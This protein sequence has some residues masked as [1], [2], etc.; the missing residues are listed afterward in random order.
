MATKKEIAALYDASMRDLTRDQYD[1]LILS[2]SAEELEHAEAWLAKNG[3]ES[4]RVEEPDE[5]QVEVLGT[6]DEEYARHIADAQAKVKGFTLSP[7]A[8]KLLVRACENIASNSGRGIEDRDQ[9]LVVQERA[10][11]FTAVG[12]DLSKVVTCLAAGAP[13]DVPGAVYSTC[14]AV[15]KAATFAANLMYRSALRTDED[16]RAERVMNGE[17]EGQS[18]D[19]AHEGSP[20]GLE[21]D[22]GDEV[23]FDANGDR[24]TALHLGTEQQMLHEEVLDGFEEL[25]VYLSVLPD[26]FGWRDVEIMPYMFIANV[27]AHGVM[28]GNFQRITN[29]MQALDLQEVR[30]A[31]ARS[32][33]A[34]RQSAVL[35][36]AMVAARA[37]MLAA[38]K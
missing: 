34:A 25:H 12:N 22:T 33:R 3:E 30:S 11:L 16:K 17:V 27:D 5:V 24:I 38:S 20:V 13:D 35:S 9:Q 28:T 23:A 31:A 4:L 19:D 18:F 15:Q 32:K 26:A 2:C 14:F 8:K 6:P 29:P 36:G 1:E 7:M 21:P 37:M 10:A